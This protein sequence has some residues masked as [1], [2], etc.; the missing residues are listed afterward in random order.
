MSFLPMADQ[1]Y[2]ANK[3]IPFCEAEYS[4][5]KGVILSSIHL[6][7]GKFDAQVVDV[8]ILLPG[9]YPDVSPDMFYTFPWIRIAQAGR[10]PKAAD[11]PLTFL[12]K[13]WQRW[14]RH[15]NEW[16]PGRDGIQTMLKRIE[17]ALES[18]QV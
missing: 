3:G 14:S 11:Q 9:G 6:P 5:Q 12:D 10:Y 17:Y 16:R 2:L 15:S 4:G 1:E 8:L 18:A 13:T 7:L